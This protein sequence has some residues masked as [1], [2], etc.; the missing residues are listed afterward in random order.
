[1][2]ASLVIRVQGGAEARAHRSGLHERAYGRGDL[3]GNCA[4]IARP[5]VN[6]GGVFIARGWRGCSMSRVPGPAPHYRSDGGTSDYRHDPNDAARCHPLEHARHGPGDRDESVGHPAYLESVCA[7]SRIASRPSSCRRPRRLSRTCAT[8]S[9]CI[10]PRRITR[11]CCASI[12]N[13]RFEPRRPGLA[14]GTGSGRTPNAR[15]RVPRHHDAVRRAGRT[16]GEC[17]AGHRAVEF[18]RFLDNIRSAAGAS[19]QS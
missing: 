14:A 17:H 7:G 8:S 13:R 18:R 5:L 4:C 19:Q 2:S 11:R 1:M 9:G 6:G 10:S 3:L 15:L 16:I 12:K